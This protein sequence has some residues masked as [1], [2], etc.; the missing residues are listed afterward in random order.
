MLCLV[1]ALLSGRAMAQQEKIVVLEHADSLIGLVID[2][3]QAQQL[4]GHVKFHQGNIVV[5]CAKA[6]RYMSSNKYSFEGEAELWD[7]SMRMVTQRGMYYGDTKIAEGFDRVMLEE[8]TT[9]VN[10][11][12]GK[13]F[14]N[15]KK[16]YFTTDV[17][18]E[19][20]V[21]RLTANELTYFKEEQRSIAV[22]N[23]KIVNAENG[24][25]IFG[26]HFENFRKQKFSRMKEGPLVIQVDT[27]GGGISDTLFVRSSIMEA[28]QDSSERL[29]AIDSVTITRGELAAEAG[30]STFYTTLDSM[31]LR[32]SP[33]IWYA[34]SPG[35]EHQV[36]GD[37]I[38]IKM[39]N[40]KVQT[41]Y[42]RGDAFAISRSDST[43]RDRFNQMTGQEIILQFDK[44]K[45]QSIDVDRT[46]TSLYYLFDEGKGNGVNKSTG[47]HVTIMFVDGKIDA[48]KVIGGTE[49]QYFPEKMILKREGDY[50]LTG[51]NW[52]ERKR[53][54]VRSRQ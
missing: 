43:Y 30:F 6:V 29:V 20:R 8:S 28:Y 10:A 18:V 11:K 40:R 46:A 25:T 24:L 16:A 3:E 45:V 1:P 51:F 34:T 32:K 35:D 26:N 21:S 52:K 5:T 17:S 41:A 47:D 31:I 13:Y 49:G 50:N 33:I 37:S 22:G 12:Y 39:K 7:G 14:A 9:T 23:V 48:I 4:I 44:N 42:V 2:G 54:S 19:D 38:F 27:S 53:K 36:S 15:E